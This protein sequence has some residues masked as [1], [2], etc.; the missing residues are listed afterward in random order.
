MKSLCKNC[1][2]ILEWK[3]FRGGK[4]TWSFD[5]II[6]KFVNIIHHVT[7]KHESLE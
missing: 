6:Q 2:N 7:L 1:A 5:F 3:N 4:K